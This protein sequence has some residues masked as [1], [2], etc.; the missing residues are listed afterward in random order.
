MPYVK[1]TLLLMLFVVA[2]VCWLPRF[3]P[4]DPTK[5]VIGDLV[6]AGR[7]R[8]MFRTHPVKLQS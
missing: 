4:L 6:C 8:Y 3:F 7:A 2:T 1:N 5:I